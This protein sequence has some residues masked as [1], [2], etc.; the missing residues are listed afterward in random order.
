[1]IKGERLLPGLDGLEL[2]VIR[3]EGWH[4]GMRW[5]DTGLP[6]VGTSPNIPDFETALV[7]PGLCFMEATAVSEGRGTREPFK[8]TGV[9]RL[10]AEEL[11][12]RLNGRGLPGVRFEP[13]LFTPR[14]I[15]GMSSWP[16]YRNQAVSGVRLLITDPG[17]YRPVETGIHLLCALYGS[18]G[19]GDRE[20][21]FR[22]G[23]DLLAG[24]DSLRRQIQ[25]GAAPEEIVA[26]W[27]IEVQRF[28]ERRVNY[29]LY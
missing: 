9:P 10:N 29:L 7:Y 20:T 18:L 1:M 24:T 2:R 23:F 15:P 13:A 6:W 22:K 21:F 11:A 5:P 16:K 27:G 19:Q 14:R 3:M 25:G 8:V 4:R 28:A 26:A 17:A 12:E